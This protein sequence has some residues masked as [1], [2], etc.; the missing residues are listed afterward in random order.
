MNSP[1]VSAATAEHFNQ[2]IQKGID[3]RLFLFCN[4]EPTLQ[5][6]VSA[7]GSYLLAIQDLYKFAIDSSCVLKQYKSF[8]GK[9]MW[10]DYSRL[11]EILDTISELRTAIDHNRSE[12]N[13]WFDQ[14]TL[15]F[16]KSW[17]QS[18]IAKDAADSEED[19]EK[20]LNS[21]TTIA[22]D[23]VELVDKFASHLISARDKTRTVDCWINSTLD[24]YSNTSKTDLY[25]GQLINA[26]IARISSEGKTIENWDRKQLF[27]NSTYWITNLFFSPLKAKK[28]ALTAEINNLKGGIDPNSPLNTSHLL[29]LSD[30]QRE[31]FEAE[32]QTRISEKEA[33]RKTLTDEQISL[34]RRMGKDPSKFFFNQ[35]KNQLKET[36]S[37]LESQ[38]IPYTL[39]PQ[40][41]LQEDIERVF[42]T[43]PAP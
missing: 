28:D 16:Y 18:C 34:D 27:D 5:G 25:R 29:S 15:A 14:N 30:E 24:W 40:S 10:N 11:G 19:Y 8:L 22:N 1:V 17:L 9:E 33:A 35:L 3:S 23:L 31:K 42:A 37:F 26:Y 41:L 38:G 43:I 20:L 2:M 36:M 6:G 32:I 4:Y 21:L 13:G 39:L 7:E 12:Y